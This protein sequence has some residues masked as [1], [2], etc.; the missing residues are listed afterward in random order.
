SALRRRIDGYKVTLADT[1][2]LAH[3]VINDTFPIAVI[4]DAEWAD[5]EQVTAAKLNLPRL[6]PLIT[7]PLP[8]PLH[9]GQLLGATDYLPKPVTKEDLRDALA[10]LHRPPQTILVID[11][12]PRLVRLLARLLKTIHPDLR[13]LEAFSGQE[14]LE[15]IRSQHPEVVLLD[16]VLPDIDG[17]SILEQMAVEATVSDTQFIITSARSLEQEAG[18]IKG[19]LRLGY[20]GGFT[21][22]GILQLLQAILSTIPHL[23]TAALPSDAPP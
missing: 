11:D 5:R 23:P 22:A 18:P 2:D 20:G 4:M 12:N 8:S 9:T 17:Q 14:G 7:C 19:E 10:R 21:Q 13:V 15:V 16:M 6:T 3:A 1:V